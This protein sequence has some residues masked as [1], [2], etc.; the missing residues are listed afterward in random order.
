M[1]K[2]RHVGLD[3]GGTAIKAGR[4]NPNGEIE[5]QLQ[6]PLPKNGSGQD[7]LECMAAAAKRLD[8]QDA[9]GIGLPGLLNRQT[10]SIE[11]CP[12]IAAIEGLALRDELAHRLAIRP[13]NV[14]LENDA[15]AAALGEQWFG[16]ARGSSDVLV[17]TLGT[18]IGGGLILGGELFLGQGLAGEI[19]HV[20][21]RGTGRLCGCGGI[22]CLETQAS[23]TAASRRA[24]ERNLPKA[25]PGDLELL[26]EEARRGPGPAAELLLEIGR[27]LGLGL[28]TA[29]CLLDLRQIV[30]GGGFSAA[31]D[32]L[33]PGIDAGILEGV[34]GERAGD[35]RVE[36]AALGADAGWIGAARL[37]ASPL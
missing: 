33:K 30:I 23:A 5:A 31:F 2:R 22:D 18:G 34:W 36:R 27:D 26:T 3:V 35:I 19:G 16:A 6:I 15:N 12:N 11:I 9:L 13:E 20:K 29:V 1:N 8:V 32:L 17:V 24:R 25:G 37:V 10:G 7:L 14:R 4:I 28:S 21:V